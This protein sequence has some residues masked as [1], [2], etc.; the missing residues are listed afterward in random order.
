MTDHKN[1]AS[2]STF[3]RSDRITLTPTDQAFLDSE[4][5]YDEESSPPFESLPPAV[6]REPSESRRV[7]GLLL[8]IAVAGFSSL[9]L[10]A[11]ALR[12]LVL[13]IFF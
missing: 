13:A 9:V 7:G 5:D 12:A 4:P 10:I 2:Q 3:P 11:A 6:H 8:F 1:M